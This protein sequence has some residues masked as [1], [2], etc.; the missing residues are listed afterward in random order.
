MS[1]PLRIEYEG[2]FY[3]VMSRGN[4]RQ[5]I[6]ANDAD[7]QCFLNILATVNDKYNWLIHAYCLMGNHYHLVVETLEANLSKG[8]RQL[9][10]VYSQAYNRNHRKTGHVF[11]GRYKALLVQKESYLLQVAQYIV[12]NP[13]RAKITKSLQNYPW[14]SYPATAGYSLPHACLSTNL[15]LAEFS[16]NESIAQKKY[17]ESVNQGHEEELVKSASWGV[18]GSNEFVETVAR[19]ITQCD[20]AKDIPRFQRYL[21]RPDLESLFDETSNKRT[22]NISIKEAI[23]KWAYDQRQVADHLG[24][25]ESTVSRL[26]NSD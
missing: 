23:Y 2:A 24:L 18:V 6:Y 4:A 13:V 22:R 3:H 25:H 11:E 10:G 8:M 12:R 7:R 5:A 1:R 9:N 14:S 20:S 21:N 15:I 19:H 17:R 26:V 16:Q